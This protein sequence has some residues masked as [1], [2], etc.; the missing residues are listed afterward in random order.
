[1]ELMQP[2]KEPIKTRIEG[3]ISSGYY[4]RVKKMKQHSLKQAT[5]QKSVSKQN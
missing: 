2:E 5:M 1:M 4:H 3:R